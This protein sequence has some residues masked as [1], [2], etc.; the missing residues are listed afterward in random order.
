MEEKKLNSLIINGMGTYSGGE[1]E[2]VIISGKGKITSAIKCN[3][4]EVSGSASFE[5]Q[6]NCDRGHISGTCK[7]GGD[8]AVGEMSISGSYKQEG[9]TTAERFEVSGMAKIKQCLSATTLHSTGMLTVE[10]NING[11]EV[12]SEGMIHC[13]GLLNCEKLDIYCIGGCKLNE[14]GAAAISV[15]EQSWNI[16]KL[17]GMF[18]PELTRLSANVMEGDEIYLENCDVKVVRGRNIKLGK[19]CHIDTLEY[20]GTFEK[21]EASSVQNLVKTNA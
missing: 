9:T 13:S 19:N 20:S 15:K 6:I 7:V 14:V 3:Y 11:E 12:R 17:V 18:M 10:G 4:L 1:F 16:S 2:R 5:N 8:M 21:D